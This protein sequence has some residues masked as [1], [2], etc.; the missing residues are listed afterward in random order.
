M[1]KGRIGVGGYLGALRDD[2]APLE[3]SHRHDGQ[4]VPEAQA[5]RGVEEGVVGA[6]LGL[7]AVDAVLRNTL[8]D[9]RAGRG[10][11]A[12]KYPA[13][14]HDGNEGIGP[15]ELHTCVEI[16]FFTKPFIGDDTAVLALSSG[17]EPA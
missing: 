11:N 14:C 5:R 12:I 1:Y 10:R 13:G 3:P 9:D 6:G 16:R 8:G 4:E 17:E 2:G 15:E 7:P